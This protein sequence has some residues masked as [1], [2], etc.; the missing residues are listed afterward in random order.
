MKHFG[1]PI[2][3][4]SLFQL[5][6]RRQNGFVDKPLRSDAM[7]RRIQKHLKAA[8]LFK[9]E[10]LYSFCRSAVQPA[11]DIEGYDVKHLTKIGR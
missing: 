7:R 2:R 1:C 9:G 5:L 10:T 4:D 6:N 11:A 8:G 3:N